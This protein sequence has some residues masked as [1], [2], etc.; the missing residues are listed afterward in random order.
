M[1][2]KIHVSAAVVMDAGGRA[3]LVRKR[4][5]AY[6]MQPGGKPEPGENPVQTLIRELKEELGVRVRAGALRKLGRF[7]AAAANEAGHDVIAD[8][9]SLHLAPAAVR[10]AAEIDEARW[11]TADQLETLQ[12]APL[13]RDILLPLVWRA[14][15]T[16]SGPIV[17]PAL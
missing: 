9:F 5:T 16:S 1:T 14:R 17:V 7:H 8:A 4:D 11:V 10:P 15:H 6:F 3:L 13:S 2:A 12:V